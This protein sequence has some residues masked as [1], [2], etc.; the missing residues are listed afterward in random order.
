M[1]T[2]TTSKSKPIPNPDIWALRIRLR[3]E[4]LGL[5]QEKIAR[6]MG[7]TRSYYSRLELGY[8]PDP[9][10]STIMRIAHALNVSLNSLCDGKRLPA[11]IGLPR[12]DKKVL[13][14]FNQL[15]PVMRKH[16]YRLMKGLALR[17][18]NEKK[19]KGYT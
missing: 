1:D 13:E 19:P 12:E 11:R 3:R 15:D 16:F 2:A 10:I 6:R 7:I 4:Q 17:L 9:H 14:C 18:S 8:F 5:S